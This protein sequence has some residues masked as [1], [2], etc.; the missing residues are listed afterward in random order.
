VLTQP[1]GPEG[2]R[3]HF[4]VRIGSISKRVFFLVRSETGLA[5]LQ[6]QDFITARDADPAVVIY[7]FEREPL[8]LPRR[9]SPG[10]RMPGRKARR[11]PREVWLRDIIEVGQSIEN[12]Q[13]EFFRKI[14]G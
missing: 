10:R 6:H 7:P 12:L 11:S 4:S 3:G 9:T 5:K 13:N 1:G 14:I 8:Q 2:R